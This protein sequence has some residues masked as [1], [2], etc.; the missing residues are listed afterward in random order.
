MSLSSKEGISGEHAWSDDDLSRSDGSALT[1]LIGTGS[2]QRFLESVWE[3]TWLHVPSQE[4]AAGFGNFNDLVTVTDL[5]HVLTVV[6]AAGLRNE[7]AV[8]VSRGGEPVPPTEWT[9]PRPD[10]CFELDVH[11]LLSLYRSGATIVLNGVQRSVGRVDRLCAELSEFFGVQVNANAY[12]TPAG[13]QGFP[14]HPD[15]HDVYLLQISGAKRWRLYDSPTLAITQP[16]R[17]V[18]PVT[19]PDEVIIRT[20]DVLYIPR[21]LVHEGHA[22][23]EHASVH[24]TVGVHPYTWAQ[25]LTDLVAS[26]REE[27]ESL[28]RSVAPRL[29]FVAED[30]NI[31]ETLAEV[32]ERLRDSGRVADICARRSTTA[33]HPG[34]TWHQGRLEELVHP[35]VIGARTLVESAE[36]DIEICRS[37]QVVELTTSEKVLTFPAFVEP[38][39]RALLTGEARCAADLESTLD[40]TSCEVLVR[41]LWREGVLRTQ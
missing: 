9:V 25:L 37:D 3:R 2:V 18:R 21:G 31:D 1:R 34:R 40:S 14:P 10:G 16:E 22:V 33:G 27:D 39:L 29:G 35:P 17:P 38:Q 5:D 4:F 11:R 15:D 30:E 19:A 32:L 24:I 41:R 6:Q 28:R 8:R 26:L 36:P 7:D 23:Q 12:L 20:G 13:A